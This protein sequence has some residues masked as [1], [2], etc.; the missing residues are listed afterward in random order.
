MAASLYFFTPRYHPVICG[1]AHHTE[2][3]VQQLGGVAGLLTLRPEAAGQPGVQVVCTG[4]AWWRQWAQSHRGSTLLWQYS[5][6]AMHPRGMPWWVVRAMWQLRRAGIRQA[7][8]FHEVQIRYSVPGLH[9]SWR[10]LQ[11]QLIA[12]LC[13]RL[14]GGR[15][16][17]SIP[18]YQSY[19]WGRKPQ[20]I[21]ISPNLLPVPDVA[22][23]PLRIVGFANRMY[24]W[25]LQALAAVQQQ[26]PQLELVWLGKKG[27]GIAGEPMPAGFAGT[28][29]RCTGQLSTEALAMELQQATLVLLPLEVDARSR[30]GISLKSGTL[31]AA[32]GMGKAILA[33]PGDMT[34]T[35]LLQHGQVLHLVPANTAAAWQAAILELLAQPQY[36]HQLGQGARAFYEEH[37]SWARTAPAYAALLHNV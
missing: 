37:L 34:D 10:A 16:G 36:A 4:Q 5:P 21:P 28:S 15:A 6:Y 27:E 23:V 13:T 22:A 19:F 12:N 35:Q 9:N 32:M 17:T 29:H 3:L 26:Y 8:F 7:L 11:Q 18:L 30:G 25:L 2:R 33:S 1:V 20:L 14:A 31:S 24:P